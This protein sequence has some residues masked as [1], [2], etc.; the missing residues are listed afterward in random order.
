MQ[1]VRIGALLEDNGFDLRVELVAGAAG[2]E[3]KIT[4][5]RVQ[6]PGLALAGFPT[7]RPSRPIASGRS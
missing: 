5:S 7:W 1:S 6:K 4:S 2:L 3:R